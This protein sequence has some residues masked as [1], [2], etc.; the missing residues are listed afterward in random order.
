M[1]RSFRRW[2][3]GIPWLAAGVLGTSLVLALQWL[4]PG[5]AAYDVSSLAGDP[6]AE[7]PCEVVQVIAGDVVVIRQNSRNYRLRL[8][9]ISV[10]DSMAAQARARLDE[11]CRS[12]VATI[13]LDK[14]RATNSGEA[15]AWLYLDSEL[16]ADHLVRAGLARFQSY[17]G[18]DQA[19]AR[20]LREA[21]DEAREL[22]LGCWAE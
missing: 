13:D 5:H 16:A 22:K 11:L 7:G 19:L 2:P 10:P 1:A 8:M 21:Q 15:L 17:P 20:L 4:E 18:D 14:R 12:A 6:P 9:G 3:R